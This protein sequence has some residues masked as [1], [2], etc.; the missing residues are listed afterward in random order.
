MQPLMSVLNQL[1][2]VVVGTGKACLDA[3]GAFVAALMAP[4]GAVGEIGNQICMLLVNTGKGCLD[5]YGS[6]VSGV[7]GA[8]GKVG[9]L[10]LGS[11]APS[12]AIG[13]ALTI[14]VYVSVGNT[15]QPPGPMLGQP[16]APISAPATSYGK[17]VMR[18]VGPLPGAPV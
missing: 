11:L 12:I 3:Y 2:G 17:P 9:N 16:S 7:T 1:C 10:Q 8:I 6:L 5:A 18:L 15:Q 4:F 13:G 14:A